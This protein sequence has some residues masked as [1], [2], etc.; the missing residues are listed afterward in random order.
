MQIYYKINFVSTNEYYINIINEQIKQ[1]NIN[2][3]IKKY[4]KFFILDIND[5]EEK[6]TTFFQNLK[7]FTF[8]YSFKRC[9]SY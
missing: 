6:I 3:Q 5:E 1:D 9:T 4:D 2:I 8:V 7:K